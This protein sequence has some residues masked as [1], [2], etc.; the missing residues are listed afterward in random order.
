MRNDAKNNLTS[1]D[2]KY[3]TPDIVLFEFYQWGE[4]A[5]GAPPPPEMTCGF[6]MQLVFYQKNM[7]FI[8]GSYAIP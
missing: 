7:W 5:G 4:G 6:L 1:E 2:G 8:G 3:A